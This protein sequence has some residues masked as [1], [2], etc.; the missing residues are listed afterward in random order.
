MKELVWGLR[1]AVLQQGK[2][3]TFSI[4]NLRD[5]PCCQWY[6]DQ[7]TVKNVQENRELGKPNLVL[8][9]KSC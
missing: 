5:L 1:I 2:R 6:N 9:V 4:I 8:L 7:S 3:S